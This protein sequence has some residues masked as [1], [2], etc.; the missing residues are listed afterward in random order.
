MYCFLFLLI[1]LADTHATQS[2]IRIEHSGTEFYAI[3]EN[4]LLIEVSSQSAYNQCAYRCHESKLCRVFDYDPVS[5]RCRM[6]EGDSETTGRIDRSNSATSVAGAIK[7]VSE[8]FSSYGQTCA[9]CTDSR[10]LRCINSTC[11]CLEHTFWTGMV[12]ASQKLHAAP[13]SNDNHCRIDINLTC[14][15]YF[16]CG[17]KLNSNSSSS[18]YIFFLFQ[19]Y[20]FIM[21]QQYLDI[22]TA[23][24]VIQLRPSINHG[25]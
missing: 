24:L 4:V 19:Q 11:N 3:N 13:C 10:F 8:L 23:P 22:L 7:L 17:R 12:C 15:Q 25:D 5:Q 20:H 14:L 18:S 9:R 6:F 1:L 21:E 2:Y 16:Q